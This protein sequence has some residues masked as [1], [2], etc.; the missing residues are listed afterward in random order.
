MNLSL[1]AFYRSL[2]RHRLYAAINIGGLAV[3]IAVF[4]VLTIY[5]RFENS[6]EKWLPD[7]AR[8]FQMETSMNS[9]VG[10]R[11]S[12]N[13]PTALWSATSRDLPDRVGTRISDR[14][15]TVVK[16]GIGVREDLA[17]VD[18]D[19]PKLFQLPV[20]AGDF[21]HAFADPANIVLTETTARKYFGN[22]NPLG[23]ALTIVR[24][25]QSRSYRV[26]AIVRDLP[27]NTD[28]EFTMLARLVL[29]EN[30]ASPDYQSDHEWNYFSPET[31][32]RVDGPADAAQLTEKL[33]GVVR[34]H[35]A[36][37]TPSNDV[38]KVV[39]RLVPMSDVRF[40][41]PGKRLA[42]NTLALVGLLTLLVAAVNYV[43]LATARAGLRAREVA[44]RKVLGA[45]RA[46]LFRHYVGE[47]MA[48]AGLAGLLGLALAEAA[49]PAV[50]AAGGLSLSVHYLGSGGILL[51]LA[52]LVL[53]VGLAA[54]LYPAHV[55]SRFPVAAV[56]ASARSPGGG[57]AGTRV[58][59]GLVVVQFAIAIA[60]VVGTLVLTAQ[61]AHVR[62]A[63]IGFKRTG[64]MLVP[65]LGSSNLNNAQRDSILHRL[66]LLPGVT[67][68]TVGNNA[69]GPG[70]FKSETNIA[71]PG[72]P[73][74]GPSFRFFQVT[75]GFFGTVGARLLAGRLFSLDRAADV[76]ANYNPGVSS[77]DWTL[78]PYNIVVNRA[79]VAALHLPD[80]QAAIGRTFVTPRSP[81]RT[82]IGVVENMRFEDARDPIPP[83]F[84]EFVPRDPDSAVAMLRFTGD[85]KAM[86]D[87]VQAA[88]R[89][90]APEVPFDAI[91]ADQ[92]LD[93]LYRSD[94]RSARL[95]I[96][97]AVLAVAIGCVGLWGLAS[98]NTARRVKE[99]G[100]RK[101]LGAST[102]DIVRLLVGQF[103]R[104][105][106]VANLVAWPLAFL[107]MRTWL[108]GFDDRIALSPWFFV[109]A[110]M[111]ALVIAAG[112]VTGQSL[113]A[114]RA[115]PAWALR[116][117]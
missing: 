43:N 114:A 10:P 70:T 79:A 16:D 12:N 35:A 29:S 51:P 78:K 90:E 111:L 65:S 44:M 69:P 21:A 100:I 64:L 58:R 97:G 8:L 85:A 1:L 76:D 42:V 81:T 19:F 55:L 103:L 18:Q 53:V 68:A 25:G 26:A 22:A 14:N 9:A 113:R 96:I 37:E 67:S 23:R 66:S 80:P 17:L 41:E 15:V 33:R 36:S 39:I 98:F 59:E 4:L 28:L 88:W 47:A 11:F 117:E 86:K 89:A 52:A 5:V 27:A 40:E 92:N 6:Y 46:S 107:A 94:D 102:A 112:T 71:I 105:V 61:T 91:T 20:V 95:F 32:V 24:A 54:G 83:T 116:H 109:A 45:N 73:G 104:P 74:Q 87:K 38:V 93:K 2:A 99:I 108:A 30:K 56:L 57:R 82:I 63:D 3:G 72:Q 48:T 110:S 106:L 75:P 60:F 77:N 13:S 62:N 49:M 84:Y 115:A 34:R 101:T 7:H 50:N 31:F